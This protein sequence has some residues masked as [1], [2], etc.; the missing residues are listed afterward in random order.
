MLERVQQREQRTPREAQH[1]HRTGREV[2]PHGIQVCDMAMPVARSRI[3]PER[4]TAAAALV[5]VDDAADRRCERVKVWPQH[6]ARLARAAVDDDQHATLLP[7]PRRDTRASSR[8]TRIDL[9]RVA[10]GTAT[11]DV[12]VD[13][14]SA[15][16]PSITRQASPHVKRLAA[17]AFNR[18][19]VDPSPEF[20]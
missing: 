8:R 10:P 2:A 3:A 20:P 9:G 5:I 12:E 18:G 17:A 14:G 1:I 11:D 15:E 7:D 16:M 4:R 19:A 6:A 13:V